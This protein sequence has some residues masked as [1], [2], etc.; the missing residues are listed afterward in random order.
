MKFLEKDTVVEVDLKRVNIG[1]LPTSKVKFDRALGHFSIDELVCK[2][3]QKEAIEHVVENGFSPVEDVAEYI[4][5]KKLSNS[6][7][8]WIRE[9][10]GT[11]SHNKY[12][13]KQEEHNRGAFD[14]VHSV[15]VKNKL[16]EYKNSVFGNKSRFAKIAEFFNGNPLDKLPDNVKSLFL[17][18]KGNPFNEKDIN[19]KIENL[20][21][22][23]DDYVKSSPSKTSFDAIY[24]EKNRYVT[25]SLSKKGVLFKDPLDSSNAQT[26]N[27]S[28]LEHYDIIRSQIKGSQKNIDERKKNLSKISPSDELANRIEKEIQFA[29]MAEDKYYG[30]GK[31]TNVCRSEFSEIYVA[32]NEMKRV[33]MPQHT[34]EQTVET[35]SNKSKNKIKP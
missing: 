33:E 32:T 25:N 17:D 26:F 29:I 23:I 27:I 4:E 7:R 9:L 34:Q 18:E 21:K 8:D 2:P 31:T 35:P 20:D 14:F 10:E 5:K 28:H 1:T 12:L 16:E 30:L 13:M 24:E 19:E 22:S 3:F 6:A 15:N 11:L